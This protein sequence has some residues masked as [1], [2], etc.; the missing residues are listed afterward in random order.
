MK[1]HDIMVSIVVPVYNVES[2]LSHCLGSLY[3]AAQKTLCEII[4]VNDGSTDNSRV[5]CE[6][7]AKVHSGVLVLDKPN[8]G[9]SDARNYGTH[10]ATGKYVYY[11]DA[12]DWLEVGAVDLLVEYAEKESCEIVQGGFFYA[13][14]DKLMHDTRW[15]PNNDKFFVLSREEAMEQLIRNEYIKNFAWGKLYRRDIVRDLDFPKGKYFE[16]SYWQHLAVHRCT[17]YGVINKPLYYYRQRESSISGNF[18]IRNL[19]LLYGY[20]ERLAFIKENYPQYESLML[21]R[22]WHLIQQM[23]T[24]SKA[25][26]DCLRIADSLSSLEKKHEKEFSRALGTETVYWISKKVPFILPVHSLALRVL[27]RLLGKKMTIIPFTE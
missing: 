23:Q 24:A 19:D 18:S 3:E 7:Y 16:D 2:Y 12:D 6:E 22:L 5:L 27:T 4:L 21:S 10:K 13:Y 25:S 8:G 9:L 15:L 17:R 14:D 26:P 20:E 1:Q 11:L